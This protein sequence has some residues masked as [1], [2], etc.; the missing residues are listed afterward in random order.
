[1]YLLYYPLPKENDIYLQVRHTTYKVKSIEQE[2][3]MINIIISL[4]N[5]L[6]GNSKDYQRDG[7][8]ESN[9]GK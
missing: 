4:A 2:N 6:Q 7:M 8:K 3:E 5:L 9:L 1:M